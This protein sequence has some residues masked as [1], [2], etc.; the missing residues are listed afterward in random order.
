MPHRLLLISIKRPAPAPRVLNSRLLQLHCIDARTAVHT[1]PHLCIPVAGLSV[2]SFRP[3]TS[4][5]TISYRSAASTR[6]KR[7]TGRGSVCPVIPISVLPSELSRG[8]LGKIG[9]HTG[10]TPIFYSIVGV[11]SCVAFG[12][13][14]GNDIWV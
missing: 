7:A 12:V 10:F 2:R 1:P 8:V 3:P 11:E 9:V 13:S 14:A 6:T 4:I 5:R